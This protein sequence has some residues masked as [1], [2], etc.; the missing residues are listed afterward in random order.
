ME[1]I[2]TAVEFI[3]RENNSQLSIAQF[4]ESKHGFGAAIKET[5]FN[6][7]VLNCLS[8]VT[9]FVSPDIYFNA[10]VFIKSRKVSISVFTLI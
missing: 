4:L 2:F 8:K 1:E 9:T 3:K 6:M 5:A 7:D 10:S